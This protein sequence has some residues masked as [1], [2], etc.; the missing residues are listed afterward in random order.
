M[1]KQGDELG[2]GYSYYR[3]TLGGF[4]CSERNSEI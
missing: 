1:W 3:E 2:G 4:N